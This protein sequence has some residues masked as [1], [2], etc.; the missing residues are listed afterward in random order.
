MKQNVYHTGHLRGEA[1]LL[2][3]RSNRLSSESLLW[4][5][6]SSK[7]R[8][9]ACKSRIFQ[10]PQTKH[11]THYME[12]GTLHTNCQCQHGTSM[13]HSMIAACFGRLVKTTEA[14][15]QGISSVVWPKQ[16]PSF[17]ELKSFLSWLISNAECICFFL[18]DKVAR[19][20]RESWQTAREKTVRSQH[21]QNSWVP[22]THWRS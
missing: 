12:L 6:G 8:S 9:Q 11:M 18:I 3:V 5:K 22:S 15:L 4:K 2:S 21:R 13:H 1:F 14:I 16:N 20:L 7:T 17:V 10:D 19:K